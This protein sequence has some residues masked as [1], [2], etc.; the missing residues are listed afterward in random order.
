MTKSTQKKVQKQQQKS[1][2]R[3]QKA[4]RNSQ[5]PWIDFH[6]VVRDTDE[7]ISRAQ[8]LVQQG[9]ALFS[10]VSDNDEVVQS[11]TN[12]LGALGVEEVKF[13]G[14]TY[15]PKD[16]VRKVISIDEQDKSLVQPASFDES[17]GQGHA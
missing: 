8:S 3:P 13:G 7:L 17:S 10:E 11:F 9:I 5:K 15:N 14:K 16:G 4:Q 6:L 1:Q 2:R 12:L